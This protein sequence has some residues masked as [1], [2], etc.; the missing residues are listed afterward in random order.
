MFAELL[1]NPLGR[2]PADVQAEAAGDFAR[3]VRQSRLHL[4]C[5]DEPIPAGTFLILGAAS[6]SPE[7]LQLLD[8]IDAM[9][10]KWA[11]DIA[12]IDVF[13]LLD[14][15]SQQDFR[16]F[17]PGLQIDV[18]QSPVLGT[19]NDRQLQSV[20]TGLAATRL[21]LQAVGVL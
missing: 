5:P 9:H 10:Q 7:E 12:R 3:R 15:H 21:R 13:N 20:V 1:V 16:R 11:A 6:Y 2:Q 4:R 17:L 18:C 19:W 14:C 8:D